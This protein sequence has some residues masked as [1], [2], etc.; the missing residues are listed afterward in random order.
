MG[1]FVMFGIGDGGEG[2]GGGEVDKRVV[3][4]SGPHFFCCVKFEL[5]KE[6]MSQ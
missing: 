4:E 2:G 6:D 1:F 5:G 3:I